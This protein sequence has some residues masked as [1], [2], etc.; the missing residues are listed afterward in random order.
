MFARSADIVYIVCSK[1]VK[2]SCTGYP[3]AEGVA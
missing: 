3:K 2:Y 1:T